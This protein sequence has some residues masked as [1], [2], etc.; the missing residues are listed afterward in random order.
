MLWAEYFCFGVVVQV[1]VQQAMLLI[2]MVVGA[3]TEG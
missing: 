1:E 2:D 3:K